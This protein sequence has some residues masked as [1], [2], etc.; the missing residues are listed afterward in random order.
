MIPYVVWF[1]LA[2]STATSHSNSGAPLRGV[3]GNTCRSTS[4]AD[5]Q[6]PEHPYRPVHWSKFCRLPGAHSSFIDNYIPNHSS[7]L[8]PQL[9]SDL[10]NTGRG[11][12]QQPAGTDAHEVLKQLL[13]DLSWSSSRLEGNNKSLL[14]TKQ[15][16]ELGEPA[17]PLDEDTLML[18]DH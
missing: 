16:F 15:L 3:T 7:L 9:A 5:G 12:D 4:C 18:L 1:W 6:P 17:G 14:D 10:F 8:P 13:I 2:R 11:R